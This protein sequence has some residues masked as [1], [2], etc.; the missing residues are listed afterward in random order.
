M[1]EELGRYFL[2]SQVPAVAAKLKLFTAMAGKAMTL[3]EVARAVGIEPRPAEFVLTFLTVAGLVDYREGK[4]SNTRLAEECLVEG[5]PRYIGD[6][7]AWHTAQLYDACVQLEQV[8]RTN[9]PLGN[10]HAMRD[11][12]DEVRRASVLGGLQGHS[13]VNAQ[14]LARLVDFSWARRLLDVAGGSGVVSR[15]L[16]EAY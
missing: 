13:R 11:Q 4:Y 2:M 15:I 9:Q 12:D 3:E 7:V 16:A 1:L 14:R 8:V 5:R 10:I 6:M